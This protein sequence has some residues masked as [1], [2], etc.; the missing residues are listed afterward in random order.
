MRDA[1][2]LGV[3]V[4]VETATTLLACNCWACCGVRR[5]L[6][7]VEEVICHSRKTAHDR[8]IAPH[9]SAKSA[10]FS[11]VLEDAAK[12]L[13]GATALFQALGRVLGVVL[14]VH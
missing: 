9:S 11:N 5:A 1:L 6:L 14:L 4:G 12:A 13:T 10:I 2:L 8:S 3:D 7:F